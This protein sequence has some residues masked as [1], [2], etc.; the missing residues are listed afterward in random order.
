MHTLPRVGAETINLRSTPVFA[1]PSGRR[2]V[3]QTDPSGQTSIISLEA[4]R[5]L[6]KGQFPL[7]TSLRAAAARMNDTTPFA[8]RSNEAQQAE[9][10]RML[11]AVVGRLLA[12][13]T[14][15][16]VAA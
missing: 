15:F 3:E 1:L 5:A 16:K 11:G 12:V 8:L 14:P 7:H 4:A 6:K 10:Q 2:V 9:T 13:Q